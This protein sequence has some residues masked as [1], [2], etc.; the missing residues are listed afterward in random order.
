[1]LIKDEKQIILETLDI[2]LKTWDVD[3]DELWE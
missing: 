1:M 2:L 3:L